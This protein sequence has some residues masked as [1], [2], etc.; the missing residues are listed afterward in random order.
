MSTNVLWYVSSHSLNEDTC[1]KILDSSLDSFESGSIIDDT[2]S[3]TKERKISSK[4]DRTQRVS[5]V[6]RLHGYKWIL[7]IIT[8]IAEEANIEAGWRYDIIGAEGLQ[9]T[10]YKEG[11]FY[12]WHNDGFGDHNAA[13]TYGDDP[14]K[15]VRKLSMTLLLNDDYEGGEFEIN[16]CNRTK[17]TISKPE[18][19]QGSIVFFP[20]FMEHR[21]K[22][23]TKGTRYSLVGWF[24]GLPLR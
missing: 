13:I 19:S 9:L 14:N 18:L 20:S 11:G 6:K 22:P 23:V 4:I 16:S 3:S 10:R 5:D 15:Y 12:S 24:L 7:D 8:P 17:C 2:L 21:V 1:R